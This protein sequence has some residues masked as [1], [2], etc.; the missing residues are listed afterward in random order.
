MSLADLTPE[1]VRQA[2]AEF[3]RLGRDAFLS[4]CGFGKARGYFLVHNG[5]V[6]DSKAIAGVAHQYALLSSDAFSGGENSAAGRLRELGFAVEEFQSL[7]RDYLKAKRISVTDK[8]SW[9]NRAREL[10][11]AEQA[12]P[13]ARFVI[14]AAAD[15]ALSDHDHPGLL[16]RL[17]VKRAMEREYLTY[18]VWTSDLYST[19]EHVAP[20]SNPGSG[21]DM[22]IYRRPTTRHTL[23][24]LILLPQQENAAAGNSG[25]PRKKTFY[26][27]L[28][29][30]N[31][32]DQLKLIKEAEQD[33]FVFPKKTKELLQT[34]HTLHLL[35]PIRAVNDW[36]EAFIYS[37]TDNLLSLAW[38]R[39]APWLG[40]SP[41]K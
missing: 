5:N 2:I 28:T 40:F 12:R 27:A 6:Y 36:D 35:D 22:N 34:G 13:L 20:D 30:T 31:Q 9:I 32:M 8:K 15:Q 4:T 25:W 18:R 41:E 21:W 33:G 37:R 10:P 19:V 26:L 29:E 7:L 23:G 24:N 39:V 1:A 38:D 3:D 14:L 17:H 11:L 16:T